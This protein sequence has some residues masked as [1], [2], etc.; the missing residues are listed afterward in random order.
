MQEWFNW[1]AWKAC[2]PQKGTGG[3]NPP[4][5]AKPKQITPTA[6]RGDFCFQN[7]RTK[8][9]FVKVVMKTKIP[10]FQMKKPDLL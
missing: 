7:D 9:F 2:V 4:L 3:S 6:R 1:H 8:P 5:S 10:V